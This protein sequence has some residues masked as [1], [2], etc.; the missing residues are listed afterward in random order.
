MKLICVLGVEAGLTE[1]T[2][3]RLDFLK[4]AT[5]HISTGYI[6]LLYFG[7]PIKERIFL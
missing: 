2:P 5:K 4:K 7:L 1:V 3:R 6:W